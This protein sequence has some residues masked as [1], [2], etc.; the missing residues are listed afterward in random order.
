MFK[1]RVRI[2]RA[3]RTPAGV[4]VKKRPKTR[5]EMIRPLLPFKR[6][7]VALPVPARIPVKVVRRAI[8]VIASVHQW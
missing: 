1:E 8:R 5:S 3:E 4:T 2:I 6:P 7:D